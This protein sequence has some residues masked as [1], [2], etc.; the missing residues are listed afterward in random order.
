M[1]ATGKCGFHNQH[2]SDCRGKPHRE[3]IVATKKQRRWI[4]R[5]ARLVGASPS[6]W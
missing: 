5:F 6:A 3:R 1:C 4:E 2:R